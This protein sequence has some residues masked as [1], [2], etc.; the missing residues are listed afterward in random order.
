MLCPL[1]HST[2]VP[3]THPL[4]FEWVEP[5]VLVNMLCPLS[6][7]TGVPVTHP[8]IF[9]WVEPAVLVNT[10]FLI[11]CSSRVPVASPLFFEWVD[12]PVDMPDLI[13]ISLKVLA[14]SGPDDSSTLAC[15]W[16][17]SI[18]PAPDTVSQNQTGS[19]PVLHSMIRAVCGRMPPS[20][21]VGN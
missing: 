13:Q 21:R 5:A 9:E 19:R 1:S 17:G 2:G 6:H 10:L 14:K 12:C 11:S 4:I 7:S 8:L 16:T 15:F 3:V 20:L 18:W